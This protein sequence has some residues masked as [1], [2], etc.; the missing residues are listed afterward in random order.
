MANDIRVYKEKM[1]NDYFS[2]IDL[3]KIEPDQIKLDLQSMLGEIPAVKL[4][5]R[6]E[7]IILEDKSKKRFEELE[8][9]T[10]AFTYEQIITNENGEVLNQIFPV[11]KTILVK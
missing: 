9:V 7:V 1:I 5:Y 8:S 4:N 2:S 6:N 11:I 3:D 10:V